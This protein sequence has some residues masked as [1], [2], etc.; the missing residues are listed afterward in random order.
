MDAGALEH[1]THRTTGDHTGTRGRGTQEDDAGGGKDGADNDTTAKGSTDRNAEIV[2]E[3]PGEIL[4]RTTVP[5]GPEEGLTVAAAWVY[6]N[7]ASFGA[8]SRCTT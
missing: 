5:L 1:R 7:A 6:K 4:F 2:S 3:S 8:I